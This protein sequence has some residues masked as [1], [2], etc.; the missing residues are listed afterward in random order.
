MT[1]AGAT[2]LLLSHRRAERARIFAA[3]LRDSDGALGS[4]AIIITWQGERPVKGSLWM[5]AGAGPSDVTLQ[6]EFEFSKTSK[7]IRISFPDDRAGFLGFAFWGE[8]SPAE[9]PYM[10]G[11]C[12]LPKGNYSLITI[13]GPLSAEKGDIF[14]FSRW[15][16]T[17][18]EKVRA[19]RSLRDGLLELVSWYKAPLTLEEI[20]WQGTKFI[21]QWRL[22]PLTGENA[23]KED[24]CRA[25]FFLAPPANANSGTLP[26]LAEGRVKDEKGKE[27]GLHHLFMTSPWGDGHPPDSLIL[28]P[29]RDKGPDALLVPM[30]P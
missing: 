23:E 27:Y 5:Q 18:A 13:K 14:V 20:E 29:E 17:G 2:G 15:Q 22:E 16:K 11:Y 28:D 7:E 9:L 12:E 24:Y 1:A 21:P 25:L 30:K 8:N 10:Q 19:R 4:G 3:R 26:Y 6:Q